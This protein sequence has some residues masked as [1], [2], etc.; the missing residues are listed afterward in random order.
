MHS[1]H[2][3]LGGWDVQADSSNGAIDLN[4]IDAPWTQLARNQK[5]RTCVFRNVCF[6][7]RQRSW[8]YYAAAGEFR[9]MRQ[10]RA[11]VDIW[12]RGGF[13]HMED[14]SIDHRFI[15]ER[16][17][18]VPE[19]AQWLPTETVVKLAALAPANLGHFL[20]NA[21]YPAFGAI[22]RLFG[23]RATG[24]PMQL[25]LAGHNQSD[26]HAN[27]RRCIMWARQGRSARGGGS[28]SD[29]DTAWIRRRATVI[30][31]AH[32]ALV[33][34]FVE[35][36]LP[37]ISDAPLLWE[38]DLSSKNGLAVKPMCVRKLIVGTGDLGFSTVHRLLNAT[39]NSRR[40]PPQPLWGV[41][42]EHMTHRLGRLGVVPA[43]TMAPTQAVLVVK[44]G[45]RAPRADAYPPLQ[46]L[47]EDSLAGGPLRVVP[48]DVARMPLRLQLEHVS[49]SAIGVTPDGGASFVLAFLPRGGSLVV[50]GSLERWLWAN[51]GRLR[52]HYCQP[53]RRDARLACG[54][55]T[56]TSETGDCYA[57]AAVRPCVQAALERAKRSV[58]WPV[59][60][61]HVS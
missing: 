10:V 17:G 29:A 46:Q 39:A 36:L 16:S 22:W 2:N 48:L 51:D 23:Q 14:V 35:T 34:K 49:R 61:L 50:L 32:A 20:G 13:G 56:S 26:V 40:R 45:R 54:N 58:G 59:I 3:C 57:L 43:T 6:D 38:E 37:G 24:M 53:R 15:V 12:A 8:V 9:G 47:M 41:F 55:G 28:S 27:Q 33:N 30:C 11:A 5:E 31:S 21:L 44:R 7:G 60:S 52:A 18:G 4:S 19:G 42:I 25:L 1:S